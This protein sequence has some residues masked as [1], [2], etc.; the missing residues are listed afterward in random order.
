MEFTPAPIQ[1]HPFAAEPV[2]LR[3]RAD[4][5]EPGQEHHRHHGR[6]ATG[7]DAW[8]GQ[9]IRHERTHICRPAHQYGLASAQAD[10]RRRTYDHLPQRRIWH[11][12]QDAYPQLSLPRPLLQQF[13]IS[14]VLRRVFTGTEQP[15]CGT[16]LHPGPHQLP[17]LSRPQP[18]VGGESRPRLARQYAVDRLFQGDDE[19][20]VQIC[21]HL[22]FICLQGLRCEPDAGRP[23]LSLAA[24]H[25]AAGARRLSEGGQRQPT[26]EAGHRT[27]LHLAAHPRSA[28]PYQCHRSVVSYALHQQPTHVRRREHSDRQPASARAVCGALRLERRKAQRPRQHQCDL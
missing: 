5:L 27:G 6:T 24:L 26:G 28:H 3:R 13:H 11:H 7:N 22:W 4:A 9:P 2:C 14:G 16:H 18:Q 1:G 8:A 23:R 15:F 12:H 19:R 20:R 17:P 21:R 10:G 25:R